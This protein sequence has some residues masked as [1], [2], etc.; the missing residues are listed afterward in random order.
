MDAA[1]A[2]STVDGSRVAIWGVSYGGF[3]AQWAITRTGRF[4][5]AVS[6]NGLSDFVGV[7]GTGA[8][9]PVSWDLPMGGAP[10]SSRRL[11]DC[12]PLAH[13][14]RVRTPLLLVHAQDDQV[15]P[16]AQSEQAHAALRLLGQDVTLVR[17]PGEGHL[18]NLLGRPSSRLRR[19]EAIDRFLAAH[20]RPG[21]GPAPGTSRRERRGQCSSSNAGTRWGATHR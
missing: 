5:A 18:M 8:G 4:A 15:C 9:N 11:L 7:W 21:D 20:L 19:A 13:A 14:D 3:M 2:M 10:W 17:I 6:E 16:V 12:S 1:T